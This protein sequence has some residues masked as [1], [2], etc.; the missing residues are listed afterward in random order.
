M[1]LNSELLGGLEPVDEVDEEKSES[2]ITSARDS[3]K[4]AS[5]VEEEINVEIVNNNN[6]NN[7]TLLGTR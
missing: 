4:A 5:I 1:A 3:D 2:A 6:P 7:G